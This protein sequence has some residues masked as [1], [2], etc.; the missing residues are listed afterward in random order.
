MTSC[1][2]PFG[3]LAS[4]RVFSF[5]S[6]L[7]V[8]GS[9]F[10]V[11]LVVS[12]RMASGQGGAGDATVARLGDY[13]A[14]YYARAQAVVAEEAVSVQPLASDLSANGFARRLTYELRIEWNPDATGVE[15]PATVTRHLLTVNG[16]TPDPRQQPE[17]LDPRSVSPESLT[18][19]LPERRHKFLFTVA[20]LG[21]VDGRAAIM[22][23]YRSV[24][25]EEPTTEWDKE[26]AHIDLP[27]R[28]RGR[29]WAD[30]ESAEILR[31]DEQLTGLVDIPVP[32]EQQRRGAPA[33]MTIERADTS[34]RYRRVV[35]TN[36]DETIVLPASID[37][38]TIIR[39]S[40]LPRVRITQTFSNYRRFVT[41]SRI[42]Q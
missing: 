34:I 26:C 29:V 28:S 15:A 33:Y 27:G 35:F 22:V 18:F 10:G 9:V 21:R 23:D 2:S 42:V 32:K 3:V 7:T 16:R 8:R 17:C 4:R 12:A 11:I 31:Y 41:G 39:N 37:T 14:R 38:L 30:P 24:R 1:R 40:G 36:P 13:V 19:L 6:M 20:G 5:S 25:A